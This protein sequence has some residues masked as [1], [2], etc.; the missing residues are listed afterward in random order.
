MYTNTLAPTDNGVAT[1]GTTKLFDLPVNG[2]FSH[3]PVARSLTSP[4][5]SSHHQTTQSHLSLH[6]LFCF[7]ASPPCPLCVLPSP[8]ERLLQT[9]PRYRFARENLFANIFA[10]WTGIDYAASY[11]RRTRT[12]GWRSATPRLRSGSSSSNVPSA[13]RPLDGATTFKFPS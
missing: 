7:V 3:V 13:Q 12:G 11:A 9:L 4:F 8:N 6:F 5:S 10:E 2:F 1:T